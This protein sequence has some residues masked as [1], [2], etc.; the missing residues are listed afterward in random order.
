MSVS[1]IQEP[2]ARARR[3]SHDE[4]DPVEH[5]SMIP[6]PEFFQYYYNYVIWVDQRQLAVAKELPAEEITKDR[7][8]SFGSILRVM[9]HELSAQSVWIDRFMSVTPVW[10]MDSPELSRVAAIASWWGNVHL[11]GQNYMKS[12]TKDRLAEV[13]HYKNNAGEPKAVQLWQAVFHMCQ[14]ATYHAGQLNSMIKAAGGRPAAVDF[15]LYALEM[16]AS[17]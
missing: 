3:P 15:Q 2:Q 11:R 8:F 17:S 10:L 14:H 13:L 16:G 1:E 7:G 5:E 9:Q 6:S 12:L 4:T